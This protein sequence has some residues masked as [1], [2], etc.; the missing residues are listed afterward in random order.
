M[1]S[2]VLLLFLIGV[3][4]I[5]I[6]YTK[7]TSDCPLPKI[8]Y[9]FIPRSFYDEQL[10]PDNVTSQFQNMFSDSSPW[11]N[12]Y[13]GSIQNNSSEKNYDNFFTVDNN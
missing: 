7:T 6:G 10:S 3:I 13:Q 5:T 9:R 8:Q 1:N 2:I 12:Y 11:Y 4:M